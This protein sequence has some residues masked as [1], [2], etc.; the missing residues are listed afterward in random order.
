MRKRAA[1]RPYEPKSQSQGIAKPWQE[2][3]TQIAC[4]TLHAPPPPPSTQSLRYSP[5]LITPLYNH[6]APNAP[7]NNCKHLASHFTP[8]H[9]HLPSLPT[10]VNHLLRT[11]PAPPRPLPSAPSPTL[12]K[13]NHIALPQPDPPQQKQHPQSIQ[14]LQHPITPTP[15]TLTHPCAPL[16]LA[17]L[18]VLPRHCS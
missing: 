9:S 15:K 13:F 5:L 8:Q 16:N 17:K 6:A 10:P 11:L 1:I 14:P 12:Q 18:L 4:C 3:G 7:L 2:R